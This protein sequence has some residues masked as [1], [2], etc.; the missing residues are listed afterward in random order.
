MKRLLLLSCLALT[1]AACQPETEPAEATPTRTVADTDADRAA[2]QAISDAW[3]AAARAGDP[4]AV[5]ALYTDDAIIQPGGEPAARGREAL[6]DYFTAGFSEPFDITL[7]TD[8]IVVSDAGDMAYEVGSSAGPGWTGKYLVVYRK[9][10]D[11]WRIVADSWS[12]DP[13]PPAPA[14]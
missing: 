14:D 13:P 2:V 6:A 10:V 9:T 3:G 1:F 12:V 4:D 8:D 7:S 5:I 11:G